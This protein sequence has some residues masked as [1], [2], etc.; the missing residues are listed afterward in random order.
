MR[1]VSNRRNCESLDAF[2]C[3]VMYGVNLEVHCTVVERCLLFVV[4]GKVCM[5][6]KLKIIWS[7]PQYGNLDNSRNCD[8]AHVQEALSY[9]SLGSVNNNK[10]IHR[11]KQATRR[12]QVD[13]KSDTR[14]D[15]SRL[16]PSRQPP[17]IRLLSLSFYYDTLTINHH[18]A[19]AV[20]V[21]VGS[22]RLLCEVICRWSRISNFIFP[23]NY[24]VPD[25]VFYCCVE[26]RCEFRIIRWTPAVAN[27]KSLLFAFLF[28]STSL[29]W[30]LTI[31]YQSTEDASMPWRY[32]HTWRVSPQQSSHNR[33]MERHSRKLA[34]PHLK[35]PL[36]RSPSR[37]RWMDR[38]SVRCHS[39]GWQGIWSWST[40]YEV[41]VHSVYWGHS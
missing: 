12:L 19:S 8:P 41:R 16:C 29:Q 6:L 26:R 35:L 17:A 32:W 18:F 2:D 13:K 3:I 23:T 37:D 33:K 1:A 27:F 14:R 15:I 22:Q 7:L 34:R 21:H 25:G 9:L 39:K 28:L 36:W 4:I 30:M 31:H 38:R 20:A 5:V 40:R 24:L 11:T 10:K